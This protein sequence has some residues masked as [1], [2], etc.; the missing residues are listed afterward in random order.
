MKKI[1]RLSIPVFAALLAL[2][3]L[4]VGF[5]H[6]AQATAVV[7]SVWTVCPAG[8]PT[9]DFSIIQDA[10]D[11]AAPG[12]LIQVAEGVYTDINNYIGLAQIVYLNKS[13]IIQGGYTVPFTEPPDP[14][15]HPTVL[16]AQEQGRV[17]Y[18]ENSAPTLDGLV[19]TGGD[20]TGLGGTPYGDDAGGG[21]YLW[22]SPI[23]LQNS[24]IT[25]NISPWDGGGIYMRMFSQ[26]TI[27]SSTIAN[28]Q[29][30]FGGGIYI[31]YSYPYIANN[32]IM[33]NIGVGAGGVWMGVSSAGTFE[34]NLF[35]GNVAT[36]TSIETGAGLVAERSDITLTGNIF[37][38]NS[39][40]AGG[41]GA[42]L[43][44][45]NAIVINNI[46]A[47]NL[48]QETGGALL[49]DGTDAQLIHNTF[50]RS[51][52]PQTSGIY[53]AT[54]WEPRFSNATIVNTILVSNTIGIFAES[55]NTASLDATL[56]GNGKWANGS[57][58]AGS[59]DIVTGTINLWGDPAYVDPM[60]GDYHITASSPAVDAGIDAGVLTDIDGQP[61]PN[62]LG[63][64]IGAD[65][66]YSGYLLLYP[67]QQGA[68]AAP[69]DTVEYILQLTNLT[70]FTDTFSLV[71][72]TH[73][74]ETTLSTNLIGPL[75]NGATQTFSTTVTIPMDASWYMTDTVVV[76]AASVLSPTILFD[77]ARLTTQAYA[78]PQISVE[79]PSLSSMQ[80]ISQVITL[81]LTISNGYGVTLT[82]AISEGAYLGTAT[83]LHLDELQGSTIF[84][85]TSGYGNNA[86]CS[87]DTC[88]T[89]GIP[90]VIGTA[91]NF[92]GVNDSIQ[93]P[94]NAEFDQIEDQDRVSIA[95]WVNINEEILG[96]FTMMN[97]YESVGDTGWEFFIT[98]S[99]VNFTNWTNY[100]YSS[101]DYTFNTNEWYHVAM[102]Y[103]RN[104]G[105]IQ[106]Y[107]NGSQICNNDFSGDILDTTND[108][109]YIGYNPSGGDE[110]T[111]GLI[112]ELY[113]FNRALSSDEIFAL[114]QG[115]L[116]GDVPWL[117]VNPVSGIVLTNN[118]VTV[119]VTFDSSGVQT[120]TYTNT[121]YITSSDPLNPLVQVPVT[122]TVLEAGYTIYLPLAI[123]SSQPPLAPAPA[124]SLPG[125]GVL[126]GLV[127]AGVVG[128]WK[129]RR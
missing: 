87:G 119:Q 39:A 128:R 66:Y 89:A 20:S 91:L 118:S 52:G 99:Y 33:S 21:M 110:Y 79:P 125:V 77:T 88:P 67:P 107:V 42:I 115:G 47:D 55:G 43:I 96:N 4:L 30:T 78:P 28:N 64:D 127:V 117:S 61:R 32:T 2:A 75:P 53:L 16:D 76:T 19:I 111:H 13:V 126:V 34:Y 83:S 74:W 69:G 36:S 35:T 120:G 122:M 73:S 26:P 50:A 116:S 51:L 45:C 12:D 102:S 9:C 97:Q 29:A 41:S 24:I 72:G 90:G 38:L 101:C 44:R 1:I 59:G 106:F 98:P 23:V 123:K 40:Q 6:S 14:Q 86:S 129:R 70:N 124:S 46:F 112:D 5:H 11:A 10:V 71:L 121:L 104:L 100:G 93:I 85:D 92:D 108:P 68:S 95:A 27:I 17:F 62:G 7:E 114:Y 49:L 105:S 81:P 18:I 48:V 54:H 80:L 15:A 84:Y 103:D 82:Y 94:H 113:V 57:D 3:A 65:E 31:W 63:P 8:A 109:A 60:S 58:W 56:W 25:D 22:E 37:R